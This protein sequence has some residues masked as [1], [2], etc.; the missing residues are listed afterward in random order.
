MGGLAE[1]LFLGRL[2]SSEQLRLGFSEQLVNNNWSA[3]HWNSS[4]ED[5]QFSI[6]SVC[7]SAVLVNF[8]FK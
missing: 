1:L 5:G 7:L 4:S 3:K 2:R 6:H 8:V